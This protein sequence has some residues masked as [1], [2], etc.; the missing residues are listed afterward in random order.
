MLLYNWKMHC[1]APPTYTHATPPANQRPRAAAKNGLHCTPD[2]HTPPRPPI[3]GPVLPPKW[4]A[5]HLPSQSADGSGLACCA[6]P[7]E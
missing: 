3:R 6:W 4:F 2:T 7:L 1:I 5:L